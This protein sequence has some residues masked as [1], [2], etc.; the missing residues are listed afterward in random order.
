MLRFLFILFYFLLFTGASA[1]VSFSIAFESNTGN[2]PLKIKSADINFDGKPDLV[3]VNRL[4]N[5]IEIIYNDGTGNFS[6][7]SLAFPYLAPTDFTLDLKDGQFEMMVCNETPFAI[8]LKLCQDSSDYTF[9][10]CDTL[11]IQSARH[12]KIVSGNLSK[13]FETDYLFLGNSN[14]DYVFMIVNRDTFSQNYSFGSGGVNSNFFK[15]DIKLSDLNDDGFPDILLL[16][17][18]S[19][20]TYLQS[21]IIDHLPQTG[22]IWLGTFLRPNT[23]SGCCAN[24][25]ETADLNHDG[26][27][28]ALLASGDSTIIIYPGELRLGLDVSISDTFYTIFTGMY[29]FDIAAAD[30]NND[31]HTDI[32]ITNSPNNMVSILTGDGNGGFM[33]LL[34]FDAGT[35]PRDMVLADF[36]NDGWMDIAVLNQSANK[37][38]VLL[39]TTPLSADEFNNPE[40]MVK[41]FPNP[42]TEKINIEL[43]FENHGIH[44]ISMSDMLGR[45]KTIQHIKPQEQTISMDVSNLPQGIYHMHVFSNDKSVVKKVMVLR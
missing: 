43:P 10:T 26:M 27:F 14:R 29:N 23:Y 16:T 24:R 30:F 17:D 20:H 18:S 28:E 2:L 31:G 25:I 15:K 39:N 35:D 45:T 38:T 36:N 12:H 37:V 1:Q 8:L 32:A 7:G 9:Y 22:D 40:A 13:D 21:Y 19:G 6:G 41:I 42:A 34:S 4:D 33:P 5:T 3:W 44:T 11:N